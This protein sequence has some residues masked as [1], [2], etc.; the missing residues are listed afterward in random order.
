VVQRRRSTLLYICLFYFCAAEMAAS[1]I[2]LKQLEDIA[3]CP[4]CSEIFVD[5]R[6]LPC[7]HTYCLRCITSY[8]A[9][10]KAGDKIPCPVCRKEFAIPE[11]GMSQLPKNYFVEKVLEARSLASILRDE[12]AH[13]DVCADNVETLEGEQKHG[14]KAAVYCV[15]CRKNMCKQCY[16]LHQQLKLSGTHKLIELDKNP[17]PADDLLLKFPETPCD[18]HPDKHLEL[19]CKTCK[20]AVC[21]LCF[22]KGHNSHECTDVKDVADDLTAQLTANAEGIKAK[23]K[24][25]KAMQKK[26]AGEE[27]F[28]TDEVKK[29]ERIINKKAEKLKQLIEQH[30]K[31]LLTKLT[32]SKNRQLKENENVKEELERQIVVM[33]SFLRYSEE[34]KQKGAPCDIAKS[35]DELCVK[36][37]ELVNFNVEV[38]LPIDYT[39]TE[40][41]FK[42]TLSDDDIRR[43]FGELDITM[44]TKGTQLPAIVINYLLLFSNTSLI[45]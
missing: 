31:E 38:D 39:Y 4:I 7:I 8:A 21:I 10:K 34:L 44:N 9:D 5:T 25:C 37:A 22:A 35:A 29:T 36:G 23:I 40:V 17:L 41:T 26:I 1:S 19:Y 3:E 6:L 42:A 28:L 18:R 27:R 20:T 11:G 16:G 45:K 15:S 14:S 33:E 30:R 12:D 13:C 2:P 24:D 32:T 43:V